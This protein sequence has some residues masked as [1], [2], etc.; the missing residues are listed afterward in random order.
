MPTI[1]LAA[2][3]KMSADSA[4]A[5]EITRRVIAA[6]EKLPSIDWLISPSYLYLSSVSN[7]LHATKVFVGAQDASAHTAG[8]HTSQV[9]AAMLRDAGA[10]HV[11]LGHSECRNELGQDDAV[12]AKKCKQVLQEDLTPI[13]CVGESLAEREAGSAVSVVVRQ[14]AAV[15]DEIEIAQLPELIIA[16][17]PVWAI[18]T[19]VSAEADDV[20][21]MHMEIMQYI[22]SLD[23]ELAFRTR[24]LY[25][26]SVKAANAEELIKIDNVHGFLVGGAS[27][28][29][30][31]VQIGEICSNYCS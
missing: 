5:G 6:S 19:G 2:N 13:L 18:G 3:W 25:G 7:A 23:N 31:F 8:A 20:A 16:Y 10:T 30:E 21:V 22:T 17:E 12:V 27:L 4:A 26:G 24:I 11:I 15:L 1:L 14:L 29:E 9:S 28:T